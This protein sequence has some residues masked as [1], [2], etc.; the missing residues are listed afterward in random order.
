M[1]L[2]RIKQIRLAFVD[3][4]DDQLAEKGILPCKPRTGVLRSVFYI[5]RLM[6]HTTAGVGRHKLLYTPLNF[7]IVFRGEGLHHDAHR[8]C[9]VIADVRTSDTFTGLAAEEIRIVLAPHETAR[10]LPDRIIFG[11][12]AQIGIARSDGTLASSINS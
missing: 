9:V 11:Y 5:E 4:L 1:T 8:P 10:V 6:D 7:L 3:E 2:A 12:V